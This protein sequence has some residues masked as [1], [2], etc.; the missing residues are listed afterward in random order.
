MTLLAATVTVLATYWTSSPSPSP[1]QSS[2]QRTSYVRLTSGGGSGRGPA[3]NHITTTTRTSPQRIA[4][5]APTNPTLDV[6]LGIAVNEAMAWRAVEWLSGVVAAAPATG[7]VTTT[8]APATPTATDAPSVGASSDDGW[9]AVGICE[10]GGADDPRYGYY[11]EIS[12]SNYQ[13]YAV[14]GDAPMGV[15][16]EW[17]DMV[18]GG[19]PTWPG[20][21][22]CADYHG[23]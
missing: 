22:S 11:G 18:N 12:F 1:S 5:P 20:E 4:T 21:P 3:A 16:Q 17:G 14:A 15:Q 7:P 23:W 9:A 13:G 6:A 2:P 8:P 19:P 10:N